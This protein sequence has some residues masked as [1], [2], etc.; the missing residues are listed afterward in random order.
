MF[1]LSDMSCTAIISACIKDGTFVIALNMYEAMEKEG[2][3]EPDKPTFLHALK[4]TNVK[5]S[6]SSSL[7]SPSSVC[8]DPGIVHTRF[9]KVRL[10]LDLVT[11]NAFLPH[12]YV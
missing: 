7:S 3:I 11:G 1:T 4:T 12:S 5:S 8:D 6:S 9:V 10:S 2:S